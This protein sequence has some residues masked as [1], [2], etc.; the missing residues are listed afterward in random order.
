MLALPHTGIISI[1]LYY[2][3]YVIKIVKKEKKPLDALLYNE[4]LN[5]YDGVLVAFLA[6][7]AKVD[8]QIS[9]ADAKYMGIIYDALCVE[10]QNI[11]KIREVYK[12]ILN[13][14]K[15][16]LKNISEL[17]LK[18][19]Y[20]KITQ[21]QKVYLI[22]S[23]VHLAYIDSRDTKRS[24]ALILKI[25]HSLHF[26]LGMYQKILAKYNP[27]SSS[28]SSQSHHSSIDEYY[29][30]L[31]SKK[32]DSD[33]DIKQR[34]RKLV[35][36]YHSDILASKDLPEDMIAFAEEKLK[37]MNTAYEKIKQDRVRK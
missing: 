15:E 25:V 7:V 29:Q 13:N 30:V 18:L 4:I 35:K 14:E 5:S 37:L 21:V 36:Q 2:F 16:N 11:P 31:N 3:Y 28:Q 10:R 26:D 6:K 27:D 12:E 33:K 9:P 23:L 8:G 19:L 20:L 24:E 34:Y 1:F 32:E 17:C 22:E